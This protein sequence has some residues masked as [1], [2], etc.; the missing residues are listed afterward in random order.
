VAVLRDADLRPDLHRV[1]APTLVM[2]GA[3]D[4]LITPEK[5]ELLL[6]GIPGARLH[7]F[8]CGHFP[9]VEA[10]EAFADA[11]IEALATG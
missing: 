2:H 8:D 10:P 6:C 4:G 1:Q 5:I 11:L 7:R 9:P 3:L